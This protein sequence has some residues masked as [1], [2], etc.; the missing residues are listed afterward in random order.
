MYYATTTQISHNNRFGKFIYS[1][2]QLMALF[3]FQNWNMDSQWL[4]NY[5][6]SFIFQDG[7]SYVV[8]WLMHAVDADAPWQQYNFQI[9]FKHMFYLLILSISSST[10]SLAIFLEST[11]QC[12][13]LFYFFR[14]PPLSSSFDLNRKCQQQSVF[15]RNVKLHLLHTKYYYSPNKKSWNQ[16]EWRIV[17]TATWL[18]SHRQQTYIQCIL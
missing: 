4:I 17:H 15:T 2:S 13:Y 12:I 8:V 16:I 18:I 1:L 11:L 10:L 3:I 9:D 14:V 6:S 5:L 7:K